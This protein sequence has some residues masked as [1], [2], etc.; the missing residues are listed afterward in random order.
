MVPWPRGPPEPPASVSARRSDQ[1]H[2]V[3]SPVCSAV[4]HLREQAGDQL[5]GVLPH[6]TV[7]PADELASALMGS[8]SK[9]SLDI[10]GNKLDIDKPGRIPKEVKIGTT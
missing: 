4:T 9:L 5:L 10:N 8:A 1:C 6:G 7:H 2:I 3:P